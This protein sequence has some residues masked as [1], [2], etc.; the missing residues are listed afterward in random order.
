MKLFK[1][2]FA[3]TILLFIS[4]NSDDE[5]TPGEVN[6]AE[7]VGTWNLTSLNVEGTTTTSVQ[8]IPFTVDFTSTSKDEM[9][10]CTFTE[11]PNEVACS[12][13]YTT[14]LTVRVAGQDASSEDVEVPNSSS[15]TTWEIMNDTD[16]IFG[17]SVFDFDETSGV[18]IADNVVF[19]ENSTTITLLTDT[20]LTFEVVSKGSFTA[21]EQNTEFDF[22]TTVSFE[23]AN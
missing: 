16:L 20:S 1:L 7:L 2:L 10:S 18:D 5:G 3:S 11:N 12:G 8:G 21:Q 19:Q 17:E 15:T 14:T 4:C 9:Y 13:S 22:K 23:K 6:T